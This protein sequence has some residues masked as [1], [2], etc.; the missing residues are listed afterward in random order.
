MRLQKHEIE[1]VVEELLGQLIDELLCEIDVDDEKTVEYAFNY[2]EKT[3][4]ELDYT[5]Y[6]E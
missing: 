6:V 4:Q 1:S 5:E 3:I 2:L